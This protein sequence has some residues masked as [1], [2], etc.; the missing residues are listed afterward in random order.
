MFEMCQL[1]AGQFWSQLRT[2]VDLTRLCW[3]VV[4]SEI[5]YPEVKGE[6]GA[7]W[8]AWQISRRQGLEGSVKLSWRKR[9]WT[10]KMR[11][12]FSELIENTGSWTH[13]T[14]VYWQSAFAPETRG[15]ATRPITIKEHQDQEIRQLYVVQERRATDFEA[16]KLWKGW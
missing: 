14:L 15:P 2:V 13:V 1:T 12:E 5:P 9:I 6:D 8:P 4:S 11:V 3:A 16:P 7:G 10:Y